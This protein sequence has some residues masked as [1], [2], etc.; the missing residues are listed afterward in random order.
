MTDSLKAAAKAGDIKALEA[1]MNKSFESKG[2]T[3]RVT[4]SGALL[5]IVVRGKETLDKALLPTI[6]KGL[7]GISPKGFEQAIVTARV[8]GKADAWSHK[9]ELPRERQAESPPDAAISASL[10]APKPAVKVLTSSKKSK[11]WYQKNWLI[12]SLLI[13]FPIAGIPLAWISK[14]PRRNKIGAS[15]ASGLWLL[16]SF[17]TQ[18]VPET[19]PRVAQEDSQAPTTELAVAAE[20]QAETSDS[21]QDRVFADAVNQAMAA[22]GAA[23]TAQNS[24]DWKNVSNLWTTAIELMRAVPE[25]SQNYQA[26]Q[27]KVSEYQSNLAYANQNQKIQTSSAS[28]PEAKAF[29][30]VL[31]S[32]VNESSKEVNE[33]IALTAHVAD[34]GTLGDFAELDALGKGFVM[35]TILNSWIVEGKTSKSLTLEEE[36]EIIT[37]LTLVLSEAEKAY[38][39]ESIYKAAS[40]VAAA[41]GI[42]K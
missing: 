9:W 24:D 12:I 37:D 30:K 2:V 40:V 3:V 5:K 33:I 25:T 7:A 29:S 41:S 36:Q 20:E 15:T 35:M 6:Q 8:I 28:K 13:L 26:A 34:H 22:A 31:A 32:F 19:Q 14:W 17:L 18:L 1:L 10:P 16:L 23:Q 4:S 21:V 42:I 38:P 27:Q 11:L 39:N